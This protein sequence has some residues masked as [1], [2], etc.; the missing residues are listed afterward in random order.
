MSRR[1]HVNAKISS[2][3]GKDMVL[4]G[5]IFSKEAIRIDGEVKGE[6]R[7]EGTLIIG[8]SGKIKGNIT[9][10]NIMAGGI[11][12]GDLTSENRIEVA[13]TGRIT[14]N[15]KTKCLIIDE[16]AVFRGQCLMN[17]PGME[18]IKDV[19]ASKENLL[20]KETETASSAE[21]AK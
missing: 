3:I 2:I 7:T 16:N 6:V 11:V 17:M 21:A 10:G 15:I 13:A 8:E 9:A 1:D 14:G 4:E 12:E 20:A 19:S 18:D 5:T